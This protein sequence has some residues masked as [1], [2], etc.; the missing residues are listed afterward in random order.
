GFRFD[1]PQVREVDVMPTGEQVFDVPGALT[2]TDEN[3]L[4]GHARLQKGE[5]NGTRSALQMRVETP[6]AAYFP[7]VSGLG[8]QRLVLAQGRT[9]LGGMVKVHRDAAEQQ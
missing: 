8:E 3:Q 9:R 7:S 1:A 4:A 2:V 6:V 5:R